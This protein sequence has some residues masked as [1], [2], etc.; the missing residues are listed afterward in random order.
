MFTLDVPFSRASRKRFIASGNESFRIA[1]QLYTKAARTM[2]SSGSAPPSGRGDTLPSLSTPTPAD[3]NRYR[4]SASERSMFMLDRVIERFL[5]APPPADYDINTFAMGE[6][7]FPRP[8]GAAPRPERPAHPPQVLWVGK[9]TMAWRI[10]ECDDPTAVVVYCHGNS[11]DVR[12]ME[13]LLRYISA[14]LCVEVVAV[15]YT[16]YGL[17]RGAARPS[18][19]AC[20]EDVFLVLEEVKRSRRGMPV[21]AWGRSMGCAPALQAAVTEPCVTALILQSPFVDPVSVVWPY[22]HPFRTPFDNLHYIEEVRVPVLVLT[23]S[24]DALVAGWHARRIVAA[25]DPAR[26][27]LVVIEGAGHNDM[28]SREHAEATMDHIANFLFRPSS[29]EPEHA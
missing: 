22:A 28:L 17:T 12:G 5:F 9:T 29:A 13:K 11:E 19:E 7:R 6:V 21:I 8:A 24:D 10:R 16:G 25:S 23:G 14:A 3:A 2:A 1:H 4:Q 15:E 26:T 18:M 27:T 20:C